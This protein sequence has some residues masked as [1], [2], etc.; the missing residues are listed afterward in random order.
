MCFP[1]IGMF[2]FLHIECINV[3]KGSL[4]NKIYLTVTPFIKGVFCVKRFRPIM[5]LAINSQEKFT[6]LNVRHIGSLVFLDS[7]K[8]FFIRNLVRKQGIN[9][10]AALR[11][12]H[13]I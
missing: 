2:S 8:I 12:F 9:I 1:N 4:Q 13:K 7:D 10:H 11:R 6:I 3:Q 5:R